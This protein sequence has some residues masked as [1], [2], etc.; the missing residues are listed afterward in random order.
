MSRTGGAG[1]GPP[2]GF[3]KRVDRLV[4]GRLPEP[5]RRLLGRALAAVRKA[6]SGLAAAARWCADTG[7]WVPLAGS[8]AFGVALVALDPVH[9]YDPTYAAAVYDARGGLLGA[10][11][12]ADGQWR[13]EP[14]GNDLPKRYTQVLMVYEDER[15]LGHAGFDPLAIARAA[16]SNLRSRSIVSGGSTLT[17]QTARLSR[18]A[19]PRTMGAKLVELWASVRLELFHT[20]SDILGMYASRA[21]YGANVVGLEAAGFRWFGR[22]PVDLTWA[23]A[24]TL[25]I[26]P[27]SPGLVHPGRSRDALREHRDALLGRLADT[28]VLTD[29]DL[30]LATAEALPGEPM[31]MPRAAYHLA[32]S[33]GP[34]RTDT[35]LDANVQAKVEALAERQAKRL[36]DYGVANVA[37]VVARVNDGAIVA[38]VGNVESAG[39][40]G[41]WQVDCVRA[42]RSSGSILK[43]F[44]YAAM[45]DTG[46]LSPG[47]LI[48]DIPTRVGSYSPENNLKT[49]AG[50]VRADMALARSLNVPFV[51]LLRSYGVERFASLLERLGFSTLTRA[52]ADYGLTLIL[53]GAEATLYDAAGAY[54]C[55]A[56]SAAGMEPGLVGLSWTAGS[57]RAAGGQASPISQGAA[58][59]TLGALTDVTR[60]AD[61]ASW[62]EYASSLKVAWKT[63]TSFGFRDA[64]AIGVTRDYV[65]AVWAGNA[66]G[67]GRPGL[68]GTQSA[69]PLLFD[70][71]GTLPRSAWFPRPDDLV[72]ISVCSHSGYVAGP[73]CAELDAEL[74]PR[75][76]KVDAACPYC[77]LVHLSADGAWRVNAECAGPECMLSVKRFVLPPAMEWYYERTNLAYRRLPPWA[78]GCEDLSELAIEFLAP[79]RDSSIYVPVELDGSPGQTVFTAVHRDAGARL[80]WHLDGDYLGSTVGEHKMPARPE[81]GIHTLIVV[82]D[83]GMQARRSFQVLARDD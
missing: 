79:A 15:F 18:P 46:E 83:A 35:S 28:G 47:R 9:G 10:A 71:F 27:N 52:P 74:V 12:A 8:L 3:W 20:K 1:S 57:A 39:D 60:P 61:E 24:A 64:W 13:F 33:A 54:L 34:G 19:G 4:R 38:W 76:A 48:P 26:L 22:A 45:L 11:V 55:L 16:L 29:G 17:M 6:Q 75:R 67:E 51:R 65:V 81:P 7:A 41:A 40:E 78:E 23:E 42:P 77:Q 43:P 62:Q 59:L 70:I 5:G 37:A 56:R 68:K 63:G 82:D 14:Q 31:P 69:A 25:A 21:P 30:Y 49:Y 58:W 2:A 53:G 80:Y 50:A 44:L 36:A 72:T 32:A 73:D 66:S